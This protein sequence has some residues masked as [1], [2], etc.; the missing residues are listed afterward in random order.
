MNHSGLTCAS[1]GYSA[2]AVTSCGGMAISNN[3]A[4]SA[5]A[6]GLHFS[7]IFTDQGNLYFDKST[8]PLYGNNDTDS[9]ADFAIQLNGVSSLTASDFVL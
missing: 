6:L 3:N 7:G 2:R 9:A 8:H 5:P 1:G 4:L